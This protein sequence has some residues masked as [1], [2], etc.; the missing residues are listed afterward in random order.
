MK[1]SSINKQNL[2]RE[3]RVRGL[4]KEKK[5]NRNEIERRKISCSKNE[6]GGARRVRFVGAGEGSS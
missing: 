5:K 3:R 4:K 2:Q 1:K 6:V